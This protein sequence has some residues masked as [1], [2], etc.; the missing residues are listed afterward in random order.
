[1]YAPKNI[2]NSSETNET[3]INHTIS[4]HYMWY[5]PDLRNVVLLME[6]IVINGVTPIDYCE[7]LT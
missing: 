3:T 5:L 4:T 1:M 2:E 6:E 7:Y